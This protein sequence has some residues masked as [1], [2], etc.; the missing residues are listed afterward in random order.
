MTNRADDASRVLLN[1]AHPADWPAPTPA[2]GSSLVVIGAG[3][4]GLVTA[5]G[6]AGIG[7]RVAL[8]R[9]LFSR[10]LGWRR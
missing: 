2:S 10:W 1:Y 3:T 6:V 8:V 5:A 9:Q 7:P 4:A